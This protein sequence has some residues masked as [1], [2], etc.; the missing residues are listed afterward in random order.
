VRAGVRIWVDSAALEVYR[1]ANDAALIR[2]LAPL[3]KKLHRLGMTAPKSG[4]V[5]LPTQADAGVAHGRA[6]IGFALSQW[7]EA[8]GES[9]Y[10][11]IVGRLIRFDVGGDRQRRARDV[12]A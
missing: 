7:A 5:T 12:C 1:H 4:K 10:G 8:S 9:S 3:A 6:G 2:G 11:E